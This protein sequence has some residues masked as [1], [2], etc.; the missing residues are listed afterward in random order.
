M[1]A[2]SRRL[3]ELCY[4]GNAVAAL[5]VSACLLAVLGVG[6]GGFPA[7]GRAL[8]PGRGA[9]TSA[10]GARLP[11]SQTLTVAGLAD[12]VLVSFTPQG[13]ASISA[14]TDD[15]AF[16]ALGYVQ[17]EFRLAQMDLERRVAEGRLA[18]L[19]GRA[20]LASDEF[21]LRL[22][23]LRTAQQEWAQLPTS[24]P[25]AQVL[26]AYSRGVNDYLAQARASGRWPASFS[27]ARVYPPDWT[28]VDSLAVQGELTEE[29]D[30]STTP[31]DDLVLERSLGARHTLQWFSLPAG[32]AAPAGSASA[33]AGLSRA[34]AAIL[35]QARAVSGA[36]GIA[37]ASELGSTA[38]STAWAADGPKIAGGGALLAGD[39][40]LPQT[41]PS[42]W[43]QV[44]LTAPGLAVSGVTI[45]GLPAVLIGH[46]AAIAW[47][48]APAPGQDTLYYDE[49]TQGRAYRWDG[50]WRR[51]R[52]LRYAI[53]VRGGPTRQLAV[54]LAAQGPVLTT[55]GRTVAVYWTGALGSPDVGALLAVAKAS[56]FGQFT[57]ALAGWN[58]PDLTFVYADDHG[59]I[60]AMTAGQD[61]QPAQ[62]QPWLPLP[63]TG[64]AD[65]SGLV[66]ASSGPPEYDP[67]THVVVA[68][69]VAG[70]DNVVPG[71][72]S[73]HSAMSLTSF[74][75]LQDDS[76]D[77]VAAVVIPKLLAALRG[78]RL[79]PAQ[80]TAEQDLASWHGQMTAA[81]PGALVWWLFWSGYL[82]TV[83]QPWWSAARM[84]VSL[85]P[86]G[87][88]VGASQLSLDA[89]LAAWTAGDQ[90]NAAFTPPGH[91]P[92]RSRVTP[93]VADMRTA[94]GQAVNQLTGWVGT[95]PGGWQFGKVHTVQFPSLTGASVLGYGPAPAGGDNST[96]TAAVGWLNSQLG[97]SV[98]VIAGWPAAGDAVAE[99]SYPGG[100]SENPASPWYADQLGA[101]WTGGYLP[102]PPDGGAGATIS[103]KLQP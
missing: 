71:Y 57:G 16:T 89:D 30:F 33:P 87:L 70:A 59:N 81:S 17:A 5:A 39:P 4:V 22:G 1:S 93:A 80:R 52:V 53:P 37:P 83:F 14:E 11:G 63:G 58:S 34:A 69:G 68:G 94:F 60:G 36:L 8:V 10:V 47:S 96:V 99:V 18:Q 102:M 49:Q 41:L 72:L 66:P 13:L 26:L 21:E 77:P 45:P 7:V 85:D 31:L 91:P 75:A 67:G 38:A 43:Y 103:W 79:T 42:A 74:A 6:L 24:S 101:W 48:L 54:E 73:S 61:P 20:G 97:Q 76:A 19:I 64:V 55:A 2:D 29:L 28:P 3:R 46:N 27:L 65:V 95:A 12:P 44:A 50:Q 86:D 90:R 25:A 35:A 84:P 82:T 78:F 51:P 88:S 92:R 15:D 98:R 62:G 40:D 56:D 9:W 32:S 100:Q 23:L